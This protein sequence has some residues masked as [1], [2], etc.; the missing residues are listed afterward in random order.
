[1]MKKG[2][3]RLFTDEREAEIAARYI[4]EKASLK[5]L[6]DIY[7]CQFT[8]IRNVL[9]RRGVELAPKGNRFRNFTTK[10][11]ADMKRLY[12]NGSS[13]CSIA[14]FFKTGQTVVGRILRENGVEP[15][16]RPATGSRHG[17]WKGGSISI[18]GYKFVHLPADHPFRVMAH[19]SGYVAEHRLRM[20]EKLGR[21]LTP[22]ETV[23][24]INGDR[25]DN[26]PENLEARIG[27]HGRGVVCRCADCG[28]QNIVFEEME[29]A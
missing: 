12:D 25:L 1:M 2:W 6:A 20:A 29:N 17:N 26:R 5:G 21:L 13:Q 11:I 14:S 7:G 10:E 27:R 28:S 24:H 15:R 22:E 23:H 8:T 16:G 18:A 4:N 3:Q 9:I 19:R